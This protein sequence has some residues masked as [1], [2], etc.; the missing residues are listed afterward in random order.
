MRN[1]LPLRFR[2][3]QVRE[4]V[5][6]ALR[7]LH[8]RPSRGERHYLSAD[9]HVAFVV[10][11]LARCPQRAA[12]KKSEKT[13]ATVTLPSFFA[14]RCMA[15]CM[16]QGDCGIIPHVSCRKTGNRS[17]RGC[18]AQDSC[19]KVSRLR[20][21]RGETRVHPQSAHAWRRHVRDP[22]GHTSRLDR[23]RTRR[24]LSR[25]QGGIGP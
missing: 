12:A 13:T 18:T 25:T 16:L 19:T 3:R 9:L 1:P 15:A 22:L 11:V 6:S 8:E 14:Y 2:H 7:R 20:S 10:I 21:R 17:I 24:R 23:T 5:R 4:A